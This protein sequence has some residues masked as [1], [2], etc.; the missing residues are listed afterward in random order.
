MMSQIFHLHNSFQRTQLLLLLG[1]SWGG[2]TLVK[3]SQ[4]AHVDALRVKQV[5]KRLAVGGHLLA[6]AKVSQHLTN[7]DVLEEMSEI[8]DLLLLSSD[9]F[10][11]PAGAHRN[12]G[13]G[14]PRG[15]RRH[16]P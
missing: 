8:L 16:G 3:L 5:G 7:L 9:L 10:G 15:S 6:H 12:R 13:H 2:G 1:G 11:Q 14:R 4:V